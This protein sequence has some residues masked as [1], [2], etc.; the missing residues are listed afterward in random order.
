ML[1]SNWNRYFHVC[2][3]GLDKSVLVKIKFLLQSIMV[4][5]PKH[6]LTHTGNTGQVMTAEVTTLK[7][8]IHQVPSAED[9]FSTHLFILA[10]YF[11]VLIITMTSFPVMHKKDASCPVAVRLQPHTT[12]HDMG[13]QTGKEIH[14][15]N[16]NL[17]IHNPL[18]L[19]GPYTYK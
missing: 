19:L 15:E 13:F 11:L 6:T 17:C 14:S 18:F 3:F 5:T 8:D 9:T 10:C 12:L 7:P 16:Q 2:I 1:Y 4:C